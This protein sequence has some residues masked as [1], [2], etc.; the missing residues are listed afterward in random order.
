MALTGYLG[1]LTVSGDL[2]LRRAPT[3]LLATILVSA[4]SFMGMATAALAILSSKKF[5]TLGGTRSAE[6]RLNRFGFCCALLS[7]GLMI[8]VIVL[9]QFWGSI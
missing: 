8:G 1:M 7:V 2:K 5:R 4:V 9:G 6:E 3:A